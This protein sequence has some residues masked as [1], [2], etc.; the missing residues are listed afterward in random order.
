[1]EFEVDLE[2]EFKIFIRFFD[3]KD[4]LGLF[5]KEYIKDRY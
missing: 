5:G 4:F 3:F 1:M 2:F